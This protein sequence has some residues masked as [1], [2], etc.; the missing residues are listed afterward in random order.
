[1]KVDDLVRVDRFT[2][3]LLS[4]HLA[5][6]D[7][8]DMFRE[9][10]YNALSPYGIVTLHVFWKLNYDFHHITV[11]ILRQIDSSSAKTF[12][13]LSQFKRK[14]PSNGSPLTLGV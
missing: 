11:T 12:N 14:G 5:L 8:Y 4:R 7:F 1:M 2:Y 13:S 10:N 6:D 3:K 9:A